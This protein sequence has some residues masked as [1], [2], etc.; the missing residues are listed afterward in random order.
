MM[1][2]SR[3]IKPTKKTFSLYNPDKITGITKNNIKK[4]F[5]RAGLHS[6][7]AP[8][9]KILAGKV[10][11]A[12][13]DKKALRHLF[14]LV[15]TESLSYYASDMPKPG[16]TVESLTNKVY[17]TFSAYYD[18]K[19]PLKR[20]IVSII[21][22]SLL[23]VN[24]KLSYFYDMYTCISGPKGNCFLLEDVIELMQL[25]YELHLVYLPPECIPH[26][27]EQVMT[28]G[29]IN[30]ITDAYLL[31]QDAN[32]SDILMRAKFKGSLDSNEAIRVTENVQTAFAKYW[33]LWGHKQVFASDPNSFC[34]TLTTV[35]GG[36]KG[37]PKNPG[38]YKLIICYRH[39]GGGY[40]K[41]L[42]YDKKE[43]LVLATKDSNEINTLLL[44]NR[45]SLCFVGQKLTMT[46]EE[47][48]ERIK[49]APLLSELMRLQLSLSS[50][51]VDRHKTK[52]LVNLAYKDKCVAMI[53]FSSEDEDENL[54]ATK[55]VY[56]FDSEKN[57]YDITLPCV[58]QEDLLAEV[59]GQIF[60]V[61]N[62]MVKDEL[63]T[64]LDREIPPALDPNTYLNHAL[65]FFSNDKPLDDY[66][67]V[68]M[69]V[70]YYLIIRMTLRYFLR[71]ERLMFTRK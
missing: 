51:F 21:S 6:I 69:L 23:T 9:V 48:I 37:K 43:K 70:V 68:E 17:N 44:S 40:Y 53:R 5:E 50:S 27:T 36:Y 62:D 22:F 57:V 63:E 20:V 59:K 49:R 54:Q 25:L 60:N 24:E 19:L 42:E 32:T 8:G 15:S 38:P 2:E 47:F 34:G 18:G 3:I 58:N 35:L 39:Q 67:K 12:E 29:G 7:Y 4:Q 26:L 71:K 66:S 11:N 31:T 28:D 46:K 13:N 41:V 1:Y 64:N 14:N 10:S 45:D 52:L 16:A 65:Q 30:R 55:T 56:K 33:E 61:I